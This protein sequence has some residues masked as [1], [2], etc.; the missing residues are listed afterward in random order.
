MK[1]CT[2]TLT[3]QVP[4]TYETSLTTEKL[5]YSILFL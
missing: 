5:A 2:F 4:V 3:I 1:Q